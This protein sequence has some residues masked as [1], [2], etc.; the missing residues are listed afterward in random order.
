[1]CP[2]YLPEREI[3]RR[4]GKL[5]PVVWTWQARFMAEGIAG[6]T[7][8]VMSMSVSFKAWARGRRIPFDR[9]CDFPW[10]RPE[11]AA[12]AFQSSTRGGRLMLSSLV[13]IDLDLAK[14]SYGYCRR[15]IVVGDNDTGA[16]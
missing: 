7:R 9:G 1:V 10:R 4:S 14:H 16:R 2:G 8:E 13:A 3:M 11:L 6:L 5:K 12:Q 15:F